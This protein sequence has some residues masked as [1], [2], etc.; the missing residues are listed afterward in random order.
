MTLWVESVVAEPATRTATTAGSGRAKLSAFVVSYNRAALLRTCLKALAF[1]DEV[2]VVDKSSTDDSLAVAEQLADRVISVPWSPTV[3]ETR[4]FALA[5]C[6]HE[7]VLCL[8]DDECLGPEAVLAIDRELHAPRA[9]IYFLPLRHYILGRHEERAYY[10]PEL[11]PRLFR[12]GSISFRATVHGRDCAA[13][14][15][16][17]RTVCG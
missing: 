9:D 11:H 5:Q 7:W 14:R 17:A 13:Q 8:D 15:A 4:G 10:W 12:R 3:E 16:S 2:I 1:A 6:T